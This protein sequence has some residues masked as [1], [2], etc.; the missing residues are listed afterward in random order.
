MN[1]WVIS[2]WVAVLLLSGAAAAG[3]QPA[4][5]T[6][7][8][9]WEGVIT[10]REMADGK[11]CCNAQYVRLVVNDDGTWTLR[12]ASWQASGSITSRSQSF[13]LEGHFISSNP[14]EPLGPALYHLEQMSL[15][16]SEV[17][18]GNASARYNGLHITTGITLKKVP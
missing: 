8:G 3:A 5:P 1:K 10:G 17:L 16:G 18:I 6:P 2:L 14:G 9:V 13:V 12:T 11:G 4:E 15:W 7:T